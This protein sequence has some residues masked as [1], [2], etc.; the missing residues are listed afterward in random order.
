MAGGAGRGARV[1]TPVFPLARL[2]E[3]GGNTIWAPA[4]L[5]FVIQGAIKVVDVTDPRGIFPFVWMAA[6]TL[7]P[8]LVFL[9][10]RQTRD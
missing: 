4:I 8:M 1:S 5:H 2:Y 10:P 6:S 7:L 9:S 3:L